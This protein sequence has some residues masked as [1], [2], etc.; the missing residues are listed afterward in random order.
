[1]KRYKVEFISNDKNSKFSVNCNEKDL[2]YWKDVCKDSSKDGV[3][4][5]RE[6]P[7]TRAKKIYF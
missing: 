6:Y 1:M 5:Y 4:F 2:E 3:C 7:L